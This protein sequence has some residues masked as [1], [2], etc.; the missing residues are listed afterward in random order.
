MPVTK[1]D[2]RKLNAAVDALSHGRYDEAE[3]LYREILR[4]DPRDAIA[5]HHLGIVQYNRREFVAAEQSIRQ[6]IALHDTSPEAYS[7][8]GL[9]LMALGRLDESVV[10]HRQAVQL[11]PNNPESYNN[12]ASA[13]LDK[14]ET[15]EAILACRTAIRLKPNS[16]VAYYN[17]GCSYLK[18]G[19]F[20]DAAGAFKR[21]CALQPN[22]PEAFCNLGL[23][24]MSQGKPEQAI[25]A[26]RRAIALRPNFPEAFNNL[27]QPL[28]ALRR[29]DEAADAF[30]QAVALRP[31]Y[32]DAASNLVTVL[33]KQGKLEEAIVTCRQALAA[34][35]R[36]V[37]AETEM[38]TL[39][40][41]TCDWSQFEQHTQRMFELSSVVEPFVFLNVPSSAA[42]QLECARRWVAK[43]PRGVP[44]DHRRARAPG[45]I[46]I[47]YLSADF[48]RHATAFLIAELFER[49]DKSRFETFAYSYGYDDESDVRRRLIASFDHFVDFSATP[50]DEAARRI[51]DDNIDILIDLK[52]YT[53]E[54]RSD[55]I[56]NRPAPIQVNY[57]GFPGTMGADFIDYII[58]DPFVTP[59]SH[60]AAFA[61]KIVQLPYC[62]QPND[63]Q[64]AISDRALTRS[65]FGLPDRG[66]VFCSFNG[67]YK[68]TPI[69]F[70]VWMRLLKAIPGSVLWLLAS[71]GLAE[72]NLR[73]EAAARGVAPERV[74][75]CEGMHLDMHLARHRLADLFLDTAPINAHTTASDALWAGLPILT[76]AGESFVA[77]V[78]GSLL[79]AVG[80]PELVTHSLAEYEA[81]ALALARDVQGLASLRTRL[82]ENLR[83]VPLFDIAR[84]TRD[85]EAAYLRMWE[86]RQA[87]EAPQAIVVAGR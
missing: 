25:E 50:H 31:N 10:A 15:D 27:G 22:F 28:H 49:H 5:L 18:T 11:N 19:K 23:A 3:V 2:E 33:T 79:H 6:A 71:N 12:L 46:R 65:Q 85:L 64:R 41:H 55:I 9:V 39:S 30:R 20:E 78:A 59:L 86:L 84:Y 66:F 21:A 58:G 43:M 4:K 53:G 67:T 76:C 69:F 54:A 82:A 77:R 48:R 63:S 34:D 44:F 35:P 61:E 26:Y 40:R 24:L 73:S 70:D 45:R 16:F 37:R 72:R 60:Q 38:I 62:Y 52:G 8:L 14:N 51:Y 42:Q 75:F 74:I 81:T 32:A 80:L 13:L 36:N 47:G 1:K 57:L 7:N 87:G 56:I 68:I 83:S 29:M 17:L